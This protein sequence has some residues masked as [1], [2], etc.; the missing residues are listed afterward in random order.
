MLK[1]AD[2]LL[3]LIIPSPSNVN[4]KANYDVFDTILSVFCSIREFI[5]G[6]QNLLTFCE[7]DTSDDDS[8]IVI[9][10]CIFFFN[11]RNQILYL[12]KPL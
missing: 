8:N 7:N 1:L 2:T 4:L 11:S 5:I 12:L 3:I 10:F 9:G 6:F